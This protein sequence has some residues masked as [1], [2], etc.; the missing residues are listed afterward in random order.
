M[1]LP[2]TSFQTIALEVPA[3][4]TL[5]YTSPTGY[6]SIVLLAQTT[7]TDAADQIF[8]MYHKRGAVETPVVF[9]YSI[10]TTEVL[11]A[12]GSSGRLVLE[13]GDSL[14]I[15]GSSTNLQF[16]ASILETLK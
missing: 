5:I 6:N 2:L 13:Q 8:S 7:N 4:R 15:E 12:S 3:T 11:I 14:L 1:A 9:D 16:I 10:P